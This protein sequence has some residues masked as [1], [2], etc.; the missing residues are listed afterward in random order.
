ME[1][2]AVCHY[3]WQNGV[4]GLIVTGHEADIGAEHRLIGTEGVIE[5]LS[6]RKYRKLGKGIGEWQEIEVPQGERN[7]HQR[8]A[9]DI[10][11]Q[12]TEP[13]HKSLLSVD[14]AIQHTEIILATYYSS[15]I[16]ARVDLPL[17]YDGNALLDLLDANAVG[18]HRAL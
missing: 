2:Q 12:L 13:G 5:V 11:R 8:T 17:P 16:R 3:K 4:R 14:Y 18:P 6:E 15:Q 9:A 10:V 7:E 1:D